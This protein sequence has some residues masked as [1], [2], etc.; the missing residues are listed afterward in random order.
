[1]A[2]DDRMRLL[3]VGAG[4]ILLAGAALLLS[5]GVT[6]NRRGIRATGAQLTQ[7]L[8]STTLSTV[9]SIIIG[10][11]VGL[12]SLSSS[13][14]LLNL[15]GVQPPLAL[16]LI[17]VFLAIIIFSPL[18]SLHPDN[19]DPPD[20]SYQ[21]R[22]YRATAISLVS[23][24]LFVSLLSL[25]LIRPSWCPAAIC[26][27]PVLVTNPDGEHDANLEVFYTAT[28][29]AYYTIPDAPTQYDLGHLPDTVGARLAGSNSLPY[30]AVVGIHSLQRNTRFGLIIERVA[31]QVETA[32]PVSK[33]LNVW[34]KG[35][36]LEYNSNPFLA[37]YRTEKTG[38]TLTAFYAQSP[39]T[40]VQLRP[41]ESDELDVEV[42][43]EVSVHLSFRVQVT[44]RVSDQV[45]S[46]SLT[47]PHLFDLD[48]SSQDNW[49]LHQFEDGQFV[50]VAP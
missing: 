3:L 43:A 50:P 25:V 30:R 28:Q 33:P 49:H 26:P 9:G 8:V 14:P 1:M 40:G 7:F 21:R 29:S 23:A 12:N 39:H 4:V 27:P 10:L 17:G 16:G 47:V 31:L 32:G 24:L 42:R 22:I 38:Q 2:Q 13:I 19:N 35:A 18:F 11:L 20:N 36:P 5:R 44:Y 48:I 6:L 34:M 41:G 45:E 15:I 37:T 46:H